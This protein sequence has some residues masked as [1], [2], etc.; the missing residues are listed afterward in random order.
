MHTWQ[1]IFDH[2][3]IFPAK[4]AFFPKHNKMHALMSG[5]AAP[6]ALGATNYE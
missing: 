6:I 2:G 3:Q 1:E 5:M 4:Y